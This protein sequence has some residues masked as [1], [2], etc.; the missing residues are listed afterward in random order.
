M[1]KIGDDSSVGSV[2]IRF[3]LRFIK[4]TRFAWNAVHNDGL[5]DRRK[6][7]RKVA[8]WGLWI[9]VLGPR[10]SSKNKPSLRRPVLSAV[11]KKPTF[12]TAPIPHMSD[13]QNSIFKHMTQFGLV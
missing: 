6:C 8:L 11:H 9:A 12:F 4:G 1:L 13:K 2:G 3:V 10:G 7:V 5:V